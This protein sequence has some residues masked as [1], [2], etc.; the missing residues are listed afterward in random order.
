MSADPLETIFEKREQ[1]RKPGWRKAL[2]WVTGVAVVSV[3]VALLIVFVRNT[4]HSTATPLN[5]NVPAVDVSKVPKTVKLEPG[6]TKVARE[7]IK[8]AVAR[9]NLRAAYAISGP[10]IVQGQSLK[11]WMTGN[12]AVPPYPVQDVGLAPMKIDY[13]YPKQALVEIALLPKTGS[14]VKPQLFMMELD[15]LNGKWVVNSW[16]PRSVPF[17]HSLNSD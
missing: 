11:D 12:I 10:Q 13:S 8:T 15:K 4:G 3:G 5:P 9:K 14:K 6:A 1:V 7:F 2:P 16:V 17:V